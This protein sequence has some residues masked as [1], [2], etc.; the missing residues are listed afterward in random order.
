[1]I[2]INI[3]LFIVFFKLPRRLFIFTVPINIYLFIVL[4]FENYLENCL[5]LWFPSIFI[6][7]FFFF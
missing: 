6:Y 5:Y 3:Y 7:L 2:P 1:M 4:F